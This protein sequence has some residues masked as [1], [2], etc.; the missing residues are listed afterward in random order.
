MTRLPSPKDPEKFWKEINRHKEKSLRELARLP[1]E[2]KIEI[3]EQMQRD[4]KDLLN[5]KSESKQAP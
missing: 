2:K 3:L 5:S 4:W 1:F